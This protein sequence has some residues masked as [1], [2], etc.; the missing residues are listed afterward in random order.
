MHIYIH[1]NIHTYLL[2]Y[3]LTYGKYRHLYNNYVPQ[4]SLLIEQVAGRKLSVKR[5]ASVFDVGLFL[6]NLEK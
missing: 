3:M 1:K 6:P 5:A 4:N 2:T